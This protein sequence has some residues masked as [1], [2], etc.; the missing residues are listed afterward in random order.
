MFLH[1]P[2][3]PTLR[4][5]PESFKRLRFHCDRRH[6]A[7]RTKFAGFA[8]TTRFSHLHVPPQMG[9]IFVCPVCNARELIGAEFGTRKPRRLGNI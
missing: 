7:V 5:L 1:Q 8:P 3:S 6:W 9:A 4:P 2:S